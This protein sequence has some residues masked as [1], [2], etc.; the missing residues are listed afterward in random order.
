LTISSFQF[1][2]SLIQHRSI[3]IVPDSPCFQR[4]SVARQRAHD[5]T[6]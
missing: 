1:D 6:E 5:R 4:S 3:C 2:R